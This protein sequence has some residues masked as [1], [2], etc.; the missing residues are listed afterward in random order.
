MP[1]PLKWRLQ[2]RHR[3]PEKEERQMEHQRR[4]KFSVEVRSG[5]ARF[6]VGVQAQSI[7]EA[8]RMVG[9]TYPR[10]VVKVDFPTQPESFY[11]HQRVSEVAA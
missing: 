11:V 4:V 10:G 1:S 3:K 5:T 9:G 7:R 6:R 2:G 8:L